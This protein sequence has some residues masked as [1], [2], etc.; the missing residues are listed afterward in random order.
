MIKKRE[1][2]GVSLD[3][4]KQKTINLI[5]RA[6]YKSI[7]F[8]TEVSKLLLLKLRNGKEIKGIEEKDLKDDMQ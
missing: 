4:L 1:A 5:F 8:C 6:R 2:L 7:S 3:N